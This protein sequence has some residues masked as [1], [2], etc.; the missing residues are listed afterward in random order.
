MTPE[1]RL[2]RLERLARLLY[3]AILR[4]SR[5]SR[6]QTAKLKDY[7]AALEEHDAAKLAAAER[8]ED[9]ERSETLRR[10]TEILNQAREELERSIENKPRRP[11]NRGRR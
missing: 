5:E 6:K 7:W 11:P 4:D 2:D 3:E 10:A 9:S 8:P 1:Q